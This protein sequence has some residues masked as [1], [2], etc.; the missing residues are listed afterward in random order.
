[1]R[2]LGRLHDAAEAFDQALLQVDLEG[3]GRGE[4]DDL[5]AMFRS[6]AEAYEELGDLSR[7]ASLYTTLAG[8]FQNKRWGRE[9]SDQYKLRARALNERSMMAKLQRIGTGVLPGEVVTD[10]RRDRAKGTWGTLPN[11]AE[12]VATAEPEAVHH[13]IMADDP[14]ASLNLPEI[15]EPTFAPLT[16]L[17]TE[18]CS[19]DV[20]RY[21]AASTKFMDQ[22]LVHAAIDAC[23]EVIRLDPNYVPVHMRVGEIFE[24]DGQVEPALLK[25]RTVIDI[26]I[27]REQPMVAIDAYYHF[28]EL[29]P[30][31]LVPRGQLAQLL[32]ASGKTNEASDQILISCQYPYTDW[33]AS[34]GA[35]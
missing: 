16:P 23:Y 32:R 17:P 3:I 22:G 8:V 20:V 33:P 21:I 4:A 14:F 13:D 6:A 31:S 11:A 1:M 34:A 2:A 15:S 10:P 30:D 9:L 26:Y 29:S 24:R 27:A 28:L 25:Y 5:I 35:V 19:D 7:A 12:P 18:G